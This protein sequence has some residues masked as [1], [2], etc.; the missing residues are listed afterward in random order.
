MKMKF[1]LFRIVTNSHCL[2]HM[3]MPRVNR[4]CDIACQGKSR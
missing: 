1:E 4:E 2:R 3:E